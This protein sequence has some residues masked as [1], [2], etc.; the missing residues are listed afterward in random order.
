VNLAPDV[1]ATLRQIAARHKISV[2]ETVRRAIAV[3][4]FM[5]QERAQGHRLLVSERDGRNERLREVVLL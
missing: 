2:T 1:A 3:L 5:E 4:N